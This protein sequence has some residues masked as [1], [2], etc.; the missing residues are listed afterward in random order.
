VYLKTCKHWNSETR[1][2]RSM[3]KIILLLIIWNRNK[4]T[5]AVCQQNTVLPCSSQQGIWKIFSNWKLQEQF[6]QKVITLSPLRKRP[7]YAIH[8]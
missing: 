1:K 5:A 7:H 3:G 4:T 8:S 6:R 2:Q